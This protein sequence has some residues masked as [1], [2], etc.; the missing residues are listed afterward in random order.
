MPPF[1]SQTQY[2]IVAWIHVLSKANQKYITTQTY[3]LNPSQYHNRIYVFRVQSFSKIEK[4]FTNENIFSNTNT[5]CIL[6]L[7]GCYVYL[8]HILYSSHSFSFS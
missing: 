4:L 2:I 3:Y 5:K 8:V 7:F 6:Y 1:A